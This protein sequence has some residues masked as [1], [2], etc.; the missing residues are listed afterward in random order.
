MFKKKKI[1][2]IV[3]NISTAN[4]DAKKNIREVINHIDIIFKPIKVPI[5]IIL[6]YYKN[7]RENVN[8]FKIF[9]V[10]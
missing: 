7:N 6:R 1:D 8:T 9:W 2:N 4:N 3:D 10:F 5:V